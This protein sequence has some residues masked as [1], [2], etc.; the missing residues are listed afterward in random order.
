MRQKVIL[1]SNFENSEAFFVLSK[2][3][4]KLMSM[5]IAKFEYFVLN[6]DFSAVMREEFYQPQE[7]LE[8]KTI[9]DLCLNFPKE[10]NQ[11]LFQNQKVYSNIRGSLASEISE[12]HPKLLN[13]LFDLKVAD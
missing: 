7:V 3:Q 4:R 13:N 1:K 2:V 6:D 10:V 9:N 11:G 8:G 12:Q 5:Q